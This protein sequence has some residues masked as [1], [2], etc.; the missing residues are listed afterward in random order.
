MHFTAYFFCLLPYF[1]NAFLNNIAARYSSRFS[2]SEMAVNNKID[3]HTVE[4][5]LKPIANNLLIKVKPA[6]VE[7]FGGI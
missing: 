7:T 2:L 4:G 1:S 3:S 5:Q 6:E